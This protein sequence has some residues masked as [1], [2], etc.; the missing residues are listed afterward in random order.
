MDARWR[1]T[2]EPLTAAMLDNQSR[3]IATGRTLARIQDFASSR[4]TERD[5]LN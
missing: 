4:I 1:H 2:A 5:R 3:G